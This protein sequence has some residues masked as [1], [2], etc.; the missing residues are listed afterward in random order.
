MSQKSRHNAISCEHIT[1]V[2]LTPPLLYEAPSAL[3][4]HVSYDGTGLCTL[5]QSNLQ[6]FAVVS[7]L[8][9]YMVSSLSS[10]Q[11]VYVTPQVNTRR[12]LF[13]F[14]SLNAKGMFSYVETMK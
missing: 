14:N 7:N 4:F 12:V 11:A 13:R 2:N 1:V 3:S 9:E 5:Y 10:T 8:K 6:A